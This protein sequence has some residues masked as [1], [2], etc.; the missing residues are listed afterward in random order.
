MN[1]LRQ[2]LR[3]LRRS[4]GFTLT[5][6]LTLAVGVGLNAAIFTVVDCTI[7]RPLGYRDA[8]RIYQLRTHLDEEHRST[9]GI[10]GG[11][12]SDAARSLPGV[13]SIAY[14]NNGQDGLRLNGEALYLYL[15][16]VSPQFGSVLGVQPIAG[17]LFHDDGKESH[18]AMV[19]EEFART[20][21]STPQ[22]ALGQ[23]LT[24][25][26][27]LYTISAVLPA[28]FRFP[29]QSQ[30][31]LEFP[32]NPENQNR[33]A[34]NQR[35]VLKVKPGV[36]ET[37][38]DQQIAALSRNLKAAYSEDSTKSL[39]AVTLQE[40][41]VGKLRATLQLLMGSVVLVLLI[42]CANLTH[43]QL[44]R[45]L[46]ER[47]ALTIRTVLGASRMT[48]IRSMLLQSAVLATAGCVA[49]LGV[50]KATLLFMRSLAPADTPRLADIH[51]NPDVF[52][53]SLGISL[54][55]MAVTA[56]LPALGATRTNPA[57]TINGD[58]SRGTESRRSLRFRDALVVAEIAM[59]LALSVTAVLL[60]R[61]LIAASKQ[62]LGFQP[63]RLIML[64]THTVPPGTPL[65]TVGSTGEEDPAAHRARRMADLQRLQSV[66]DEL[67]QVNG[68]ESVSAT[69]GAP[70][71]PGGSDVYYAVRGK[72]TFTAPF[73]NLPDGDVRVATP[74]IFAT[75]G[76]PLLRGRGITDS[77]TVN[78]PHVIVIDQTMAQLSFPNE[79]PIGHQIECGYDERVP[80]TIVG[81]VGSVR[82]NSPGQPPRPTMYL[83]V[84]QHPARAND[85]QI[86]VRTRM[87]APAMLDTLR[88]EL[89][90]THPEIAVLGSTVTANIDESQGSEKFR[91]FLFASFAGVS[92]L[93]AVV[94]MF[95]V[96]AYTVAQRRFEFALRFA[97]GAQRSD[98]MGKVMRHATAT[99]LLG[100]GVGVPLSV[101]LL[102]AGANVLGK[103][104][105][106]D[107]PSLLLACAGVLILSLS[108]T[109][110]PS[111]RAATVEPMQVLR[112]E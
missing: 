9:R 75:L 100:I 92:I 62:E 51:L 111:R 5:V 21:F 28:G 58:I 81:V 32:A 44:V 13:E 54:L 70:M 71:G 74:G 1:G 84:S 3:S 108:A 25:E 37:L 93:L 80:W 29:E 45:A 95:G 104:P 16:H 110:A 57:A 73:R 99:A 63:D 7:L 10:G 52:F 112:G 55:V 64:D 23:I 18:L 2:T 40:S 11:D 89:H 87:D 39:E 105:V 65:P 76:V 77:D 94:G 24:Y 78:A 79:D 19:S 97:L 17:Q 107:V 4:P 67:R 56:L 88:R 50:A 34:Y 91:T 61:Q 82:G 69:D 20:H 35:A 101:L 98:V 90:R 30:V 103:L 47:R 8:G 86:M 31:W 43:L 49:A 15:A 106:F 26:R 42:V 33:T 59:T 6:I 66:L 14:Y 27:E 41:L 36:S 53:Y 48:L 85:I 102:R 22:A 38:L 109:L 12:Y 72:Q 96:T 83:P 46:R 68:V 60:T